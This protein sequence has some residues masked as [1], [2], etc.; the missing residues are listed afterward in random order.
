MEVDDE[1]RQ[2]IGLIDTWAENSQYKRT[3]ELIRIKE[4][5]EDNWVEQ[6]RSTLSNSFSAYSKNWRQPLNLEPEISSKLERYYLIV[7]GFICKKLQ[8]STI[9]RT[10]ITNKRLVR[11]VVNKFTHNLSRSIRSLTVDQEEN[12]KWHLIKLKKHSAVNKQSREII[13][14]QQVWTDAF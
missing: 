4:L 3:L 10:H 11:R 7:A 5:T 2:S 13:T 8:I 6:V 9:S 1:F 12:G 14:L